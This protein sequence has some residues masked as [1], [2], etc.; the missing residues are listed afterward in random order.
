MK[1]EIERM[2][3]AQKDFISKI[4][5]MLETGFSEVRDLVS[6][7]ETQALENHESILDIND[8][9]IEAE[10]LVKKIAVNVK[11]I[12][13]LQEVVAELKQEPMGLLFS[14]VE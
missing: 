7:I 2:V 9:R 4:E 14:K 6:S 1:K 8:E 11:A 12:K 13:E 5:E 10:N 3:I